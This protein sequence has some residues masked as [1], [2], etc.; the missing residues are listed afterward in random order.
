MYQF[1]G[2]FIIVK[3]WFSVTNL[4]NIL[5]MFTCANV[6]VRSIKWNQFIPLNCDKPDQIIYKC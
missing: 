6:K 4:V 1:L 3:S 2:R 5:S